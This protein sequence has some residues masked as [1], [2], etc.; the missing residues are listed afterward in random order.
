V[1]T[2]T[3]ARPASS[4]AI[5]EGCSVTVFRTPLR[6]GPQ[7]ATTTGPARP[8]RPTWICAEA[9]RPVSRANVSRQLSLVVAPDF[10]TVCRERSRGTSDVALGPRNLL[11]RRE[12]RSD[13]RRHTE[14]AAN[15]ARSVRGRVHVHVCTSVLERVEHRR[16]GVRRPACRALARTTERHHDRAGLAVPLDLWIETAAFQGAMTSSS[17]RIPDAS[18]NASRALPATPSAAV[19]VVVEV[20]RIA[21]DQ[22]HRKRD[23]RSSQGDTVE[24]R[25]SGRYADAARRRTIIASSHAGLRP[26]TARRP[27]WLREAVS[28]RFGHKLATAGCA[29]R[30]AR[31]GRK[32]A[33]G[34]RQDVDCS[35]EGRPI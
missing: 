11:A 31:G 13:A 10:V 35:R 15:L 29:R 33:H 12:S 1:C 30:G 6:H 28:R 32:P 2:F 27:A 5:T 21:A 34:G 4:A 19:A 14:L 17:G 9:A 8:R 20:V 22:L 7:R 18:A 24:V 3:Y 26:L 25:R 16:G 23:A